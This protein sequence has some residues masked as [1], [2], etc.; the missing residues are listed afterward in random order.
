[1][2]AFFVVTASITS[3]SRVTRAARIVA[4]ISLAADALARVGAICANLSGLSG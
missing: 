3:A 2:A 1:M 4:G